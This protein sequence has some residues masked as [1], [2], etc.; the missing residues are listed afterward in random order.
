MNQQI[1]EFGWWI[2][3]L[4]NK[5][6]YIYYFGVFDNYYEA[7]SYKNGYIQDLS[8]EG[9]LIIDL[10]INRCQPKELTICVEPISV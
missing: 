6:M 4:T 1:Q 5:P 10:Q 3:I 7:E 9:S 2:R 8:R